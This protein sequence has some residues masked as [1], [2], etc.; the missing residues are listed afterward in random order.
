MAEQP[1]EQTQRIKCPYCRWEPRV[2]LQ[3]MVDSSLT[4]VVKGWGDP[5]VIGQQKL[6]DILRDTE[7]DSANARFDIQCANCGK[8]Y[9]FDAVTGSVEP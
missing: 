9:T 7:L 6:K 3:A 4:D 1:R 8:T 2:S 5:F